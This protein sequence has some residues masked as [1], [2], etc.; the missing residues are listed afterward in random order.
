MMACVFPPL[1]QGFGR[2][3]EPFTEAGEFEL[4]EANK[5]ATRRT[6]S[7]RYAMRL[8]GLEFRPRVG[9]ETTFG[10][11]SRQ[12]LIVMKV[13]MPVDDGAFKD[14]RA[15]E[16]VD[17]AATPTHFEIGL[18]CVNGAR[19]VSIAAKGYRGIVGRAV[20]TEVRC[21]AAINRA[22]TTQ[23]KTWAVHIDRK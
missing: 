21:Q 6:E 4:T 3:D 17:G 2:V 16:I 5:P 20:I 8:L 23:R 1:R 14:C 19:K 18:G 7:L 22:L 15:Y 10:T 12:G 11:R 9:Y 13:V